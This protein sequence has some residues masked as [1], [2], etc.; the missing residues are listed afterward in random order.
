MN[1][2]AE[3]VEDKYLMDLNPEQLDAVLSTDGPLLVLA[4]AGTGKTK[5]LTTRISHLLTERKAF[6][7]QILAVTFTNKAAKEMKSRLQAQLDFQVD[8]LWLGTFHSIAAKILRR[9]S[10]LIGFT[11]DFTIIDTDDQLRLAKQIM[12]DYNIDEKKNPAKLFL[13]LI[14]R[15]KDKALTPEKVSGDVSN[16]ANGMLL[17]L[18]TEY[19]KRLKSLNAMDFGDLLL[20]NI[21][22]F[23]KHED[24]FTEYSNKFKYILVD[25]Y[26][27]TN[28]C[29][30]K[31]LKMLAQVRHN[32]CCVGDDDQSI[33]GWR[34][35][36][37]TNILMFDRDFPNAKI[38]RLERNY[39]STNHILAAAS[40]IIAHNKERHGKELWTDKN[41]G[42]KIKLN[43]FYDEREEARYIAEE[44]EALQQLSKHPLN[45]IAILVRAGYQTRSFEESLNFLRIPYRIIG[46]FK[47]YERVEIKDTLAYIRVLVNPGDGLAFERIVNTP[48]R[49]VGLAT[50]QEIHIFSRSN[51]MSL[52]TATGELLQSGQIKGKQ[53]SSLQKLLADFKNWQEQLKSMPHW[54]VVD[55][56]LVESGYIDMWKGEGTEEAKERIDNIKELLRA[57]EEFSDLPEYLEHVSLISD[58]DNINDDSKVNIMTMHASKGLEFDSVFLAGWEEG[59]FP[60]QKSIDENGKS[61]LE[62]ERRL[63]YV[64]ITRAKQNL[65]ISYASNRRIYGSYQSSLPSR[66]IDELPDGHY[67]IVNSFGLSYNKYKKQSEA[68]SFSQVANDDEF[69]KGERVFHIKF[70]YGAIIGIAGNI[71][72]VAFEKSGV[73]KVLVDYLDS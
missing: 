32:I 23:L 16:F 46:G 56:M 41:N 67:E 17:Q 24:V 4:G 31:W 40:G 45:E 10:D 22:L 70:G 51:N 37:V 42:A 43:S 39:R 35:A 53:A 72:E 5:V 13:Y 29:Q 62:E 11:K 47:F 8:G 30:Y 44:I 15:Y 6:P 54:Q 1:A 71:A 55:N 21:E 28:V 64:G 57:L 59:I 61:A 52:I 12:K 33:Y 14:G 58:A 18:Y 9:H 68:I 69:K 38:I 50:L 20:F 66:F 49:G 7:S 73:K 65:Y 26:Q 19:Q 3:K 60:S 2:I 25:E 48:K 63:A 36:E 34:G 27:D